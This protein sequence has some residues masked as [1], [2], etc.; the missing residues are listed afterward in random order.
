[1]GV[2]NMQMP[3]KAAW[4]HLL[5]V[6]I[7]IASF[8]SAITH[9]FRLTIRKGCKTIFPFSFQNS[10]IP[11]FIYISSRTKS[12]C[13][14]H[15][16]CCRFT[17]HTASQQYTNNSRAPAAAKAPPKSSDRK[18]PVKVGS[19]TL[20]AIVVDSMNL[21]SVCNRVK[22]D[23]LLHRKMWKQLRIRHVTARQWPH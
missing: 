19:P 10:W 22:V 1:M 21:L 5:Q 17:R 18:W 11:R 9:S 8:L 6:V 12:S 16:R 15:L 23:R 20:T 13:I 3:L 14:A 2:W 4:K 7:E